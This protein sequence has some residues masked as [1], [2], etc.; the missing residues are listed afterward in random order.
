MSYSKS[1]LF[2]VIVEFRTEPHGVLD[3]FDRVGKRLKSEYPIREQHDNWEF[4]IQPGSDPRISKAGI[5]SVHF[6]SADAANIVVT[7]PYGMTYTRNFPYISWQDFTS[8]AE[9]AWRVWSK[10]VGRRKIVRLGLRS[11][12]RFDIPVATAIGLDPSEF[13]TFR[14]RP[15]ISPTTTVGFSAQDHSRHEGYEMIL[16]AGTT[17]SPLIDHAGL[18]LDIDVGRDVDVPQSWNDIIGALSEMRSLGTSV[19]EACIT[20]RA[21]EIIR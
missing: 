15:P 16:I 19:F 10:E 21:R 20:D 4:K 7:R 17:L 11:R 8:R 13:L 1:P 2:E 18:L 5:D 12:N 9:R 3:E 6:K 14:A